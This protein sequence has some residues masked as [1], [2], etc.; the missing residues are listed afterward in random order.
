MASQVLDQLWSVAQNVARELDTKP[1]SVF[2]PIGLILCYPPEPENYDLTPLNSLAFA[3]TGGDGVHYSFIETD[4]GNFD[5]HSPIIMTVP[6][7]FDNPNMVVGSNLHEFLCLG[8]RVGYFWLEQL[9]YDKSRTIARL[10]VPDIVYVEDFG[11]DYANNPD[12]QRERH[13]LDRLTQD[14]NLAPWRRIESRLAELHETYFHLLQIS[15]K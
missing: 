3:R 14:L 4:E 13:F 1:N 11:A 15:N 12:Y 10:E 5:N 2:D 7:Q 9:V 8:C 6:M